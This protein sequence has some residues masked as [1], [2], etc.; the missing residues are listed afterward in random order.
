MKNKEIVDF[1]EQFVDGDSCL[2]IP[3]EVFNKMSPEYGIVIVEE[4]KKTQIMKL[5]KYEILFFEWLKE[6]DINVWND[7]WLEDNPVE[8]PY[9]ISIAFLPQLLE[10]DG[11][12]FPVCDLVNQDNYYFSN[13]HMVDDESTML[14][15]SVKNRFVAKEKLT[16]AQL[17]ALEISMGDIDIWH[18]AYKHKI[19]LKEAKLAVF[20]LVND[21]VLVHLKAS[22]HLSTFLE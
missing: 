9:I 1:F 2:I 5:P 8:S 20:E 11:R 15:E 16:I 13:R 22:E 4:F 21:N 6:N 7:I 17:L 18:F 14:I 3:D 12:G 19:D 10:K